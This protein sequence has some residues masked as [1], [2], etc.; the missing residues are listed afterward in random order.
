[1]Q[2]DSDDT[3]SQEMLA[4]DSTQL[5]NPMT[6]L[7]GLLLSPSTATARDTFCQQHCQDVTVGGER[8]VC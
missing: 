6:R 5:S 2:A 8:L 1:M 7:E 4:E 3:G